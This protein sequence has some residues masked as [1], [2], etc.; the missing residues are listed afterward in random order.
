M[1]HMA[2]GEDKFFLFLKAAYCK[3]CVRLLVKGGKKA[4]QPFSISTTF[5]VL[6]SP[7]NSP[8]SLRL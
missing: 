3:K 8:H 4:I 7:L 5:L 1:R 6:L 2:E